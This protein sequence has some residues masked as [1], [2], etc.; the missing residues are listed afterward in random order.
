MKN[1]VLFFAVLFV[2]WG[3]LASATT[4]NWEFTHSFPADEIIT[5]GVG[6]ISAPDWSVLIQAHEWNTSG[7]Y[8]FTPEAESY[9]Y[10]NTWWLNFH[11]TYYW[12]SGQ[13]TRFDITDNYGTT[14]YSPDV[15]MHLPDLS[16]RYVH[17][18]TPA[19][20][21]TAP[22]PEPATM[23]LFGTGLA[24]L[25]GFKRRKAWTEKNWYCFLYN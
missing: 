9:L 23:L 5:F 2:M 13:V 10:D 16:N 3:G 14:F 19:D 15:P 20:P 6:D 21:S 17:I 12:D 8:V 11:D 18:N 7:T 25:V 1:F 22:V 4:M 24:G